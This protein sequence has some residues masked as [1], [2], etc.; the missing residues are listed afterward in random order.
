[1][2]DTAKVTLGKD[3]I[4]VQEVSKVDD[5]QYSL[6]KLGEVLF[7][8]IKMLARIRSYSE[9]STDKIIIATGGASQ[10]EAIDRSSNTR[11]VF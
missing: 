2:W 9:N 3:I 4:G 1:M 10:L 8:K 5:T 7:S 6:L 11:D